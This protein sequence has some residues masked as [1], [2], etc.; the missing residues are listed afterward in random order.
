M[1]PED[2]YAVGDIITFGEDSKVQ[3]PTTH[4]I[5]SIRDVGGEPQYTTK[6]D[7]NNAPDP[8]ETPMSKVIGKV[9]LAIPYAGYILDFA[10]QPIG[11]TFLIVIPAL[12][13]IIDETTRIIQEIVA[14][15]RARR[16]PIRRV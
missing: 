16:A 6:G 14:L 5:V 1:Q 12:V 4:R 11:F 13:I 2:F 7:A 9:L 10:R 15:R 8:D 3:I